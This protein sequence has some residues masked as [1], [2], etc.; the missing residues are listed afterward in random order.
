MSEKRALF[1][2]RDGTISAETGKYITRPE[3]LQILPGALEA[4]RLCTEAGFRV[5]LF[6][7]QA[8]VGKGALTLET[9]HAIHTHLLTQIEE[10]GG[11]VEAVY[12]CPHHPNDGCACRKPKAGLLWQAQKEHTLDLSQAVVI[13]DSA[14][15][16]AAGA[17][18]G[19]LCLLV[20]TGHTAEF[21]PTTF[22]SP[23]PAHVF[24]TLLDAAHWLIASP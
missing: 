19:A 10:A 14:R 16:I 22:P 21:D 15:D 3:D 8:G 17:S 18:V 24:P 20:Q 5:F 6:T 7:N 4:I 13:G 2:D 9:L 12:V 23:H 1:L 11:R